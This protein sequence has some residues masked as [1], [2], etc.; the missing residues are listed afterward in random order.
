MD[1]TLKKE[2]EEGRIEQSRML[3]GAHELSLGR[4]EKTSPEGKRKKIFLRCRVSETQ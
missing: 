4:V 2:K 3:M 1:I